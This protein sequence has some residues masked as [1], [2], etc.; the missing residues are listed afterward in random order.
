MSERKNNGCA[1]IIG[2]IAIFFAGRWSATPAAAPQQLIAEPAVST[3]S[4][5]RPDASSVDAVVGD[6]GAEDTPE[7]PALDPSDEQTETPTVYYANCS[8][9]RA[10]G[11]APMRVGDPGYAPHLDRDHDGL[12]CE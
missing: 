10:A 3:S 4:I 7:T 5:D 8:E 6:G 12:A 9:A 1:L 11:A 2:A